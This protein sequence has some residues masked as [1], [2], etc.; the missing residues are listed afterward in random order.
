MA[1]NGK[2]S[3]LAGPLDAPRK[4]GGSLGGEDVNQQGP[5]G[6]PDPLSLNKAKGARKSAK[7]YS[8]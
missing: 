1:K 8:E 5:K 6:I 2:F 3:M 4:A 7:K